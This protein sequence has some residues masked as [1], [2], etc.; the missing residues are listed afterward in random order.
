[1][2]SRI[3]AIAQQKGGVAKTTTTINRCAALVER[4]KRVLLVDLDP[5]AATTAG[6]GVE[7][8]RLE[9]TVYNV[10][11]DPDCLMSHVLVKDHPE[12]HF[13][14][15]NIDLSASEL[16]V[17]SEPGRERVLRE[18]LTPLLD[19][20]NYVLVDCPPSN[21]PS[22]GVCIVHLTSRRQALVL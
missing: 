7:P 10:L 22:P 15:A 5:Q 4:G 2:A 11:R 18:K 21:I 6:L 16:E 12:C 1:M 17:V 14:P 9:K 3:Y 19:E 20:Y 13:I 8:L